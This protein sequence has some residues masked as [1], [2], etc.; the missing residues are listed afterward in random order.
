MDEPAHERSGAATAVLVTSLP[1]ALAVLS[2]FPALHQPLDRDMA[3]HATVGWQLA[4]GGLPYVDIVDNKQ[5]LTYVVYALLDLLAPARTAALRLLAG[6]VA[7]ATAAAVAWLTRT[8]LGTRRAVLAGSLTAVAGATSWVQGVDLNTEHLFALPGTVAVLVCL[9][10]DRPTLRT[11]A[12]GGILV[13]LATLTKAPAALLALPCLVLL[14]VGR[15]G[16]GRSRH[17][18]VFAGSAIATGLPV[19]AT[20]AAAGHLRDLWFWNVTYN[21]R[22]A[23][24]PDLPWWRWLT[25][26]GSTGTLVAVGASALVLLALP[27]SDL[28]RRRRFGLGAW[29]LAAWLAGEVGQRDFPHYFA[30]AVPAIAVALAGATLRT[31]TS[32]RASRP[33]RGVA[34]GLLGGVALAAVVDVGGQVGR[35]GDELADRLYRPT[36]TGPWLV[37]EEVGLAIAEMARPGD[38]LH[39]VG[40]EPGPYWYARLRPASPHFL[41]FAFAHV[42]G[43]ADE[44]GAAL[45]A[46]PPVFVVLPYDGVGWPEHLAHLADLPYHE[47]LRRGPVT[48]LE[49]RRPPP[50]TVSRGG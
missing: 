27:G 24:S 47:V 50:A 28:S 48:V 12:A 17:T 4:T 31:P 30:P 22:Y 18:A 41:D 8:W 2:R 46:A 45:R 39:V 29:L 32:V 19:L 36:Q 11:A 10:H 1:A 9:R 33:V 7:A 43:L 40:S 20:Y 38:T 21:L 42:P 16:G 34:W 23:A 44:V 35:S 14:L 49:L 37:Q 25:V 6:L 13:G 26:E 15:D 5:P 3:A